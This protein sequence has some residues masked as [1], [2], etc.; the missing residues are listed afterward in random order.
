MRRAIRTASPAGVFAGCCS[1]RIWP[2]R[3]AKMLSIT[4]R[5]E[6][7]ARSRPRLVTVRPVGC[8]ETYAVGGESSRHPA[9]HAEE[10]PIRA[11]L[12]RGLTVRDRDQLRI[13]R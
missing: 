13:A 9:H 6:A 1:S 5:V 3:L 2:F 7:S 11:D 10:L 4:S 12:D 8:E